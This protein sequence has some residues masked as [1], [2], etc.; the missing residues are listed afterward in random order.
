VDAGESPLFPPH[1]K[2][3]QAT[4]QLQHTVSQA[5]ENFGFKQVRWTIAALRDSLSWLSGLSLSGV[6]RHLE[7][8]K[9]AWKRGREMVTSPD[10]GYLDKL[11][12]IVK[13]L[14]LAINSN[15]RIV[16]L[17][18]DEV[19]FY[20]QP[21]LAND[22]VLKGATIQPLAHRS[23]RSNTSGRIGGVVN[24]LSG[25][26]SYVLASKCGVEQLLKLYE[27]IRA[28]YPQA[29]VIYLVEDNWSV[30][31]H[32]TVLNALVEQETRFELKT[33]P[34]WENVSGKDYQKEK[35]PIQIVPLPTYA[36][37]CNPIEKLWR[38]LKQTVIHLHR[39]ADDWDK[40]KEEIKEFLN[41]FK[42]E[43]ATLLQYIGLTTNS[44]LYGETLSL[45]REKTTNCRI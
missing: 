31:F 24:A 12:E 37:W 10:A 14:E 32:P 40:L 17:F 22:Y 11:L 38:W 27:Q 19:T 30:H 28:D 42:Q 3:D 2:S 34:S 1:L 20:R 36:S 43:S 13:V 26:V 15:G 21:E 35:L 7:R 16:V 6:W 25:Q 23:H 4:E 44:K 45:I 18:A 33:P 8:A 41:Q 29:E 9:I 5:P 39:K